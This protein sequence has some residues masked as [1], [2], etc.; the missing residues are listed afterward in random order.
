MKAKRSSNNKLVEPTAKRQKTEITFGKQEGQYRGEKLMNP[1]ITYEDNYYWLR[2]D[3]KTN[4]EILDYLEQE[5]QYADTYMKNTNKLQTKLYNEMKSRIQETYDT[6]PYPYGE[7]GWNSKYRYFTRTSEGKSYP[8]YCRINMTKGLKNCEIILD[9]NEIAQGHEQCVV[10]KVTVTNDHKF[11]FFGV[12][13]NGSEQFEIKIMN[14]KTKEYVDHKIPVV[15]YADIEVSPNGKQVYY[16]QSDDA[17]R[18]YQLWKYDIITQS[19]SMLYQED[20]VK[21]NLTHYITNDENYLILTTDSCNTNENYYLDLTKDKAKLTLFE[22]RKESIK[23]EIDSYHDKFIILTNKDNAVNFKLM[24]VDKINTSSQYWTDIKQYDC[25]E[26][27]DKMSCH[28]HNIVLNIRRN[29]FATVAVVNKNLDKKWNYIKFEE[30]IHTVHPI[31]NYV[32][33][34]DKIWLNYTSLTQ[35]NI[36]YEYDM[37]NCILTKIME[38][39]VPNYD[40]TLYV[41]KL[42]Q[43]P[44]YY[45]QHVPVSVV[46]RKDMKTDNAQ[47]MYLYG[48]G[49]YGACIDPCFDHK[50][51]SLL[52]RGFIYAIA[53]IRGGSELGYQWY[54]DGKLHN[55]MNSFLDFITVAEYF[56]ANNYTSKDQL[57]IDGRSAGGLLVSTVM[58]MRP[59]LF[60]TVIAGVPFVDALVTMADPTIP[61]TTSEWEQ[62]GNPNKIEDYTYI[63]QY[64][65]YDNI[66]QTNYPNSLF[67][68][69]LHDNRVQYWEPAKFVA[70]LRHYKTD[71][72]MHLLKTEMNQGH[73]GGSDRY[74]YL[75]E[76]AYVYAFILKTFDMCK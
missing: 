24:S 29:G 36:L 21:Y 76:Y 1:P 53:H 55:K 10:Q 74:K 40:P 25:T 16:M 6:Y 33:D 35:P 51:I 44:S 22:V 39:P 11:L 75:S 15:P 58:T 30:D 67:L 32:Y 63:K 19:N 60:K 48:Y 34:T 57:A 72:N 8:I 41:S 70:K 37:K 20:D 12:D 13:Y 52:D 71:N 9:V 66:R 56:I 45:G 17:N 49:A 27:I 7:G 26:F 68:A 69:G 2:D 18:V 42:V 46:Y 61:L 5:N 73:F 62:W 43:V 54:L 23:Y 4:K 47:P 31:Y 50:R 28:D 14:L 59:D 65:P 38:K 3:N 64:S